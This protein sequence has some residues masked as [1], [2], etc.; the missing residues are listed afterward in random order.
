MS[1]SPSFASGSAR[2]EGEAA[3]HTTKR[4][5]PFIWPAGNF[6]L[7]ARVVLALTAL[8]ATKF[9]A[10]LAPI[11]QAWAVDDLAG[12]GVPDFALGAI[13]LSV[14]YG[15]S[16]FATIGLHKIRDDLFS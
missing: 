7:R 5:A 11:L 14:A 13:G 9:I 2:S 10:I 16:R 3:W 15:L 6:D 8:V 12:S 1:G 4:V